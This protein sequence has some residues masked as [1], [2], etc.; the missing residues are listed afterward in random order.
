M[1]AIHIKCRSQ[2][3]ILE[4][5]EP[6]VP[7][8]HILVKPVAVAIQP[9][10]WKHVDFIFVGD[11][12]GVRLGFEY[13]GKV[14]DIGANTTCD[15][16]IGDRV[17]GLCHATNT[18]RKDDGTFAEYAV[19]RPEFQMKIPTHLS[20][21][22]AS[23]ISSG[24]IPVC[25]GLY[26][27]LRL[28]LPTCPTR[29][30]IHLLIY[31]GST[32]SGMMGIQFA[33]MSDCTVIATCSP[34]NF[35]LLAS[36]GA[37]YCVDYNSATCVD[38][39]KHGLGGAPLKHVWDCIATTKSARICAEAM[40]PR[41]GH[42]SSLLLL[43]SSILRRVNPRIRCTTTI[44]YTIFGEEFHKETVIKRR[45]EDFVFWLGF[46]RMSE[47]LLRQKM[48]KPPPIFV[49]VGGKGF[50]GVLYGIQHLKQGKVSAGK[51]VYNSLGTSSTG[52]PE[53]A[54]SSK[55]G[56]RYAED[57]DDS[58]RDGGGHGGGRKNGT[59]SL[60]SDV[61]VAE[62][63]NN[64]KK[65]TDDIVAQNQFSGYF[66]NAH[67]DQ[68]KLC[69]ALI[70]QGLRKLNCDLQ[71]A[72]DGQAIER[73]T[74]VSGAQYQLDFCY[75]L[76]IENG[77]VRTEGGR[78]VRTGLRLPNQEPHV[79]LRELIDRYPAV[80]SVSRLIHHTGEN[81]ADIW[82]GRTDGV[83]VVF[84]TSAGKRLLEEVYGTDKTSL[85]FHGLLKDFFSRLLSHVSPE[86]APFL[87]IF[88]VGAGTGGTTRWLAPLLREFETR[89]SANVEYTFT[90]LGPGLVSQATRCFQRFPFMRFQVYDMETAA[91]EELVATQDIV[92]AVNAV[93]ATSNII[94]SLGNL[95]TLLRP[96]G[97]ALVLEVQ[98]H[99]CW[100]DFIFGL[101]EG[102]WKFNDGRTHA[103]A[104]PEVWRD[105]FEKA[106]F[107]SI[108]WTDGTTR[109]SRF[110]R[111]YIGK[112][113]MAAKGT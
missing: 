88:E 3:V 21:E 73:I 96:G 7:D 63:F 56:L 43:S 50:E 100:A 20:Y 24:L 55:Q 35:A 104:S 33:K 94:R 90:D 41:G 62:A 75:R 39:I 108:D 78:L 101:F 70:A 54:K 30:K 60:F 87:R 89:R 102:W 32:T 81:L 1:K 113:E 5:P 68:E 66:A 83:R 46:W 40:S 72:G 12:T 107:N 45:E 48:F 34:K 111:L 91:P 99:V 53:P 52:P 37:D 92:V 10:D 9:S 19:V 4:R 64:T 51:L 77:L 28:P 2:A 42:Y 29:R 103:T 8:G 26:Q 36:L 76:L 61:K 22:E 106:G 109:D 57:D 14:V 58:Q 44:G 47:T 16:K 86:S 85:A 79:I 27:D 82:T 95:K 31:G 71:A 110:Q 38:D 84:G 67:P 25:Q 98:E 74:A 69:V 15:F 59:R 49:N 18:V 13:A 17:F 97:I 23:A 11:P 112:T 65:L 93:H 80:S 105:A 6:T